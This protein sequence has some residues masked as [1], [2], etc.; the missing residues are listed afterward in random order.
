MKEAPALLPYCSP[1]HPLSPSTCI[2]VGMEET[3]LNKRVNILN[4]YQQNMHNQHFN[5]IISNN[6]NRTIK[7]RKIN[8]N[9][10][11]KYL[12]TKKLGKRIVIGLI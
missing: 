6:S 12:I 5:I 8:K 9:T 11:L 10:F 3:N 1:E 2:A 7:L 4:I